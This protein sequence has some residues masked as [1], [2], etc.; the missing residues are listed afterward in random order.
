MIRDSSNFVLDE[1]TQQPPHLMPP[2]FLVDVDG[3]PHPPELQR[4]VPGREKCKIGEL[5]PQIG[6]APNGNIL[7]T[8]IG[9]SSK[10]DVNIYGFLLNI[11][12]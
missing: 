11:G 7:L 8:S 1:Q 12:N 9:T 10:G 6:V 3:N 2:P 4:L 5:V